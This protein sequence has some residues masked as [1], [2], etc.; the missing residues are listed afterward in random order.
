MNQAVD[1]RAQ[2]RPNAYVIGIPVSI[3]EGGYWQ[4]HD[5]AGDSLLTLSPGEDLYFRTPKASDIFVCVIDDKVLEH[6]AEVAYGEEAS[7]L[8]QKAQM[9]RLDP[10]TAQDYRHL[11]STLLK[12]VHDTPEILCHLASRQALTERLIDS[13]L[14]AASSL[15]DCSQRRHPRQFVQ[16]AIVERARA[17]ILSFPDAPPTVSALCIHLKMSRRGLHHAFMNVLGISPIAFLR[18]VRLHGAR[19]SLLTA[20]WRTTVSDVACRWGFT[21][22][23]MFANYYKSLFGESPSVTQKS[24]TRVTGQCLNL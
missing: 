20:G 23:G 19:K 14:N 10:P 5:L 13:A 7:V 12:S 8:I 16:R 21:H 24:S 17:Y 1:E 15:A 4:G 2:A 18:Y 3:E 22:M 9:R 6:Y 11:L